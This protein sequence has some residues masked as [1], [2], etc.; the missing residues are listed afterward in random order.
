MYNILR[1]HSADQNDSIIDTA[2]TKAEALKKM[3]DA[4]ASECKPLKPNKVD[5]GSPTMRVGYLGKF[6]SWQIGIW[7]EKA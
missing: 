4:F 6:T 2:A 1:R 7:I 5:S 3:R